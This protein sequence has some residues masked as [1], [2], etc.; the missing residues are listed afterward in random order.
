M[1]DLAAL[2]NELGLGVVDVLGFSYGGLLAQRLALAVPDRIC[3]LVIASSSIYPVPADAFEGWAE[4]DA[5]RIAVAGV[6]SDPDLSGAELVRAAALAQAPADVW[7][8][9]RLD[10][11]LR[12]L[13]KVRFGDEWLRP[14]RAGIMPPALPANSETRLTRLGIPVLLLHGAQDMTFPSR[15]ASR[16][17]AEMP[18]AHAVILQDAGH[19]AHVDQPSQWLDALARFLEGPA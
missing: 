7:R 10:C 5:R 16:A 17:A 19:M 18:N 4:R 6:W 15:L 2:L 3:R 8:R 13:A 1:R 12:G 14:W 9:D 11:Y